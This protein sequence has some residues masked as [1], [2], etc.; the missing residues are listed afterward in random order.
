MVSHPVAIPI[1]LPGIPRV[2]TVV[3]HAADPVEIRVEV[4]RLDGIAASLSRVDYMKI[5]AE[6]G[7]LDILYGGRETVRPSFST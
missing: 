3:V 5:D 7:E 6:G 2:R 1:M 4:R